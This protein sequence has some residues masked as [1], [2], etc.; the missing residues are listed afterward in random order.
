MDKYSKNET[1]SKILDK[2]FNT[3][4]L[5]SNVLGSNETRVEENAPGKYRSLSAKKTSERDVK[6]AKKVLWLRKKKRK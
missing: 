3:K 5:D 6:P 2:I 1:D 4:I